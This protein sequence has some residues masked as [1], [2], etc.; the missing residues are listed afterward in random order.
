M[1]RHDTGGDNFCQLIRLGRPRAT[2]TPAQQTPNEKPTARKTSVSG[3]LIV[4]LIIFRELVDQ[5]L[6]PLQAIRILSV[7]QRPV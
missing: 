7:R 6:L 5:P 3:L 1:C 4:P 2:V